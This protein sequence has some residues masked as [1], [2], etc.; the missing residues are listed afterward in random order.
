[1]ANFG[2]LNEKR[3]TARKKN[4]VHSLR[5]HLSAFVSGGPGETLAEQREM[6]VEEASEQISQQSIPPKK[7][8]K[9]KKKTE[10]VVLS[11]AAV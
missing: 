7:K 4:S 1:M 6:W 8:K 3:K 10:I 9:R 11:D 5:N 2:L